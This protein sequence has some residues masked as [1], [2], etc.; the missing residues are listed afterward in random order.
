M[1]VKEVCFLRLFYCYEKPYANQNDNPEHELVVELFVDMPYKAHG[2]EI[3][4]HHHRAYYHAVYYG[5]ETEK[6]EGV[7]CVCPYYVH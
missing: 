6:S 2:H 1:L 7:V 4:E 3:A 5:A